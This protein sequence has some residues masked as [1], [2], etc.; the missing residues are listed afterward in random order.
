MHEEILITL[1]GIG[2]LSI[3]CQID[4]KSEKLGS[5]KWLEG[6]W[7]ARS[8]LESWRII[9]DTLMTGK[10]FKITDTVKINLSLALA[11]QSTRRPYQKIASNV[12]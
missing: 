9:N 3:A 11:P 2:L 6:D 7:A 12:L 8:M 5:L 1:T 10:G 4:Q